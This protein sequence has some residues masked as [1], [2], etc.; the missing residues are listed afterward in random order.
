MFSSVTSLAQAWATHRPRDDRRQR[1][2]TNHFH[3]RCGCCWKAQAGRSTR[4]LSC[5]LS[6]PSG[7]PVSVTVATADGTA[8]TDS[9]YATTSQLVEFAPGATTA[10][11]L[12]P[13]NGDTTPRA[14]NRLW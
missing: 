9:D 11:V 5:R 2:A 4:Y 3:F 6:G 12:V 7:Q 8:T 1:S 14:S 13:V 10:A